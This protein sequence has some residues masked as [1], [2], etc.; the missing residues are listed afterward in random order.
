[1][2][3]ERLIKWEQDT[4][5]LLNKELMEYEE[6]GMER[7]NK[8]GWTNRTWKN[9]FIRRAHVDVV[10]ARDTKGLWMA[11]VCLFPEF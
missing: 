9:E 3:W 2:I 7:F 11:H 8:P 4:I 10:D 1:M 5:R 6:P